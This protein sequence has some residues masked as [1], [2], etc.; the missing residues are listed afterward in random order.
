LRRCDGV[1]RSVR[2]SCGAA[3]AVPQKRSSHTSAGIIRAIADAT[4]C[5]GTLSCHLSQHKLGSMRAD[6]YR[7]SR[8]GAA[9]DRACGRS[10]V[11]SP[12][13]DGGRQGT[14]PR[15]RWDA[16]RTA[17]RC[18]HLVEV[19][20]KRCRVLPI[21][22]SSKLLSL[23]RRESSAACPTPLPPLRTLPPR[24]HNHTP[25]HPRAHSAADAHQLGV[26]RRTG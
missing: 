9:G 19:I 3:E 6:A 11:R 18:T 14:R 8:V 10:A 20:S 23:H 24:I 7:S 25:T 2:S 1:C 21:V 22:Q 16:G 26:G 12:L 5:V 17:Q 15:R 13:S 4:W